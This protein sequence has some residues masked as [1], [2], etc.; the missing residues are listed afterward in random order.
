LIVIAP[1]T[2]NTIAKARAGIADNLLLNT[3]LVAQCPVI[4]APAM[5]TQ[6]W[7]HPATQENIA[8]LQARGVHIIP[9]ATG[10]LTGADS[11]PG[12]LPEPEEIFAYAWAILTGENR[13]MRATQDSAE[14][15]S[16]RG[17]H[18]LVTAGG[19]H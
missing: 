14:R 16:L 11:G 9:P 12:R 8:V 4:M 6:M 17:R 13:E 7:E 19:T 18:I 5:H 10:Q 2:A 1:A 15:T 3:L